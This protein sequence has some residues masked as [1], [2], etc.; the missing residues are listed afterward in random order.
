M[1]SML[2]REGQVTAIHYEEHTRICAVCGVVLHDDYRTGATP[3]KGVRYWHDRPDDQDH[4]AVPVKPGEV[5]AVVR[6]DV[7]DRPATHVVEVDDFPMMDVVQPG[8]TTTRMSQGGWALDE[9]CAQLLDAGNVLGLVRRWRDAK[10]ENRDRDAQF[11]IVLTGI[12]REV[13]MKRR[14]PCQRITR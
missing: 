3:E 11:R 4:V 10:T 8:L 14:G 6:C 2:A 9:P 12:Y 5:P 7:C 13:I 1:P